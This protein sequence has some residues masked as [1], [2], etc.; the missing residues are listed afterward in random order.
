LPIILLEQGNN[1][2]ML[3]ESASEEA[4]DKRLLKDYAE[5]DSV[6]PVENAMPLLRYHTTHGLRQFYKRCRSQFDSYL[7]LVRLPPAQ[8]LSSPQA[9][10]VS[11][12]GIL[13]S[14]PVYR[15]DEEQYVFIDT[16]DCRRLAEIA[17]EARLQFQEAF[18]ECVFR[19]TP[20][21]TETSATT[22]P[23][24]PNKKEPKR[25]FSDI[26]NNQNGGLSLKTVAQSS[27]SSALY[28]EERGEETRALK[29][30]R[31][32]KEGDDDERALVSTQGELYEMLVKWRAEHQEVVARNHELELALVRH[33]KD[34]ELTEV[35]HRLEIQEMQL[36]CQRQLLAHSRPANSTATPAISITSALPLSLTAGVNIPRITR[37]SEWVGR[38]RYGQ[39]KFLRDERQVPSGFQKW[40]CMFENPQIHVPHL[41]SLLRVTMDSR[42]RYRLHVPLTYRYSLRTVL[43]KVRT[44]V[45]L[46]Q[47]HSD[48]AHWDTLIN[49]CLSDYRVVLFAPEPDNA[50]ATE[51]N[52]ERNCVTLATHL[53]FVMAA[54]RMDRASNNNKWRTVLDSPGNTSRFVPDLSIIEEHFPSSVH[55]GTGTLLTFDLSLRVKYHAGSST[56]NT[57]NKTNNGAS[58]TKVA[59]PTKKSKKSK[60]S[61]KKNNKKT[62]DD[63]ENDDDENE[64]DEENTDKSK[65]K[66]GG[67]GTGNGKKCAFCQTLA[68][69]T[70]KASGAPQ[71]SHHPRKCHVLACLSN[72]EVD[73][74]NK[75]RQACRRGQPRSQ[76]LARLKFFFGIP[77]GKCDKDVMHLDS[78]T[79]FRH[80]TDEELASGQHDN[81]LRVNRPLLLEMREKSLCK[82]RSH[83]DNAIFDAMDQTVQRA[84][85]QFD[86]LA[87]LIAGNH[88][89]MPLIKQLI[90]DADGDSFLAKKFDAT[91]K[92]KRFG[93][94]VSST[95]ENGAS[96]IDDGTDGLFFELDEA[97][98]KVT[99]RMAKQMAFFNQEKQRQ[100][101]FI[102]SYT[103]SSMEVPVFFPQVVPALPFGP[104]LDFTSFGTP[105]VSP[106]ASLFNGVNVSAGPPAF[107]FSPEEHHTLD[108]GHQ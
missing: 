108:V 28:Q 5:L 99:P 14:R 65:K 91:G 18:K 76:A 35:K 79:F 25:R 95:A 38:N 98:V 58:P 63:D 42:Y 57:T 75:V 49:A 77:E 96:V 54:Q 100:A 44:E 48:Y 60:K 8:R 70:K 33:E 22:T 59:S 37:V 85:E 39:E 7:V 41:H 34:A 66:G 17:P 19:I 40:D 87:D 92:P 29:K 82:M 71:A 103:S 62:N 30:Y 67:M 101:H 72:N 43:Q 89:R 88:G 94:S 80:A 93:S 20:A 107:L 9:T 21:A 61:N 23:K 105:T 3:V 12:A 27:Q 69:L 13:P 73:I 86:G 32:S 56:T 53:H 51:A 4:D 106:F 64:D 1:C 6:L 2:S 78:K 45:E 97:A 104:G 90:M 46:L 81:G 102:A 16:E 26:E 84:M 10:T 36:A 55:F 68:L 83:M 50:E 74:L 47:P 11:V 52:N 31:S 15:L 24:Q